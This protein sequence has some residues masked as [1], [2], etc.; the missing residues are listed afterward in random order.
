MGDRISIQYKNKDAESIVLFSH[1]D[2]MAL[3]KLADQHYKNIV[4]PLH[5]KDGSFTPLSRMEVD[6]VI[7]D[8]IRYLS[9]TRNDPSKPFEANYYLASNENNG[10]NSD[11]G[12]WVLNVEAGEW[13]H[14]W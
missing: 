5:E 2:G 14:T 10:D 6:T 3:K 11:N 7:I 1:W 12:H 4:L 13:T 9:V 8:F